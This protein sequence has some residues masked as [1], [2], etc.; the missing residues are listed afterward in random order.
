MS[1]TR[2]GFALVELLVATLVGAALTMLVGRLLLESAAVLRHRSERMGLEHSVRVSVGALRAMLEPLGVDSGSGADLAAG[3][4]STFVAR[5]VRGSG[6]LC[7]AALDRVLIR[8][9]PAWWRGLRIPVKNRDSLIVASV[10]GSERWI[11][12]PLTGNPAAGICPD[13]SAALVL[14]TAIAP[15]SLPS[16]GAGS[17]LQIIEPVE[18]R[19]Y[20]SSG[21]IWLGL[22]LAATGEAIQPLAGPFAATG[23]GLGY[24]DLQG[25]PALNGPLVAMVTMG[26]D[27]VTERAGGVGVVRLGQVQ[28]DSVR[29]AVSLRGRQ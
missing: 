24:Q 20:P 8:A 10:A 27:G 4:P 25:N 18:L 13:G 19:I 17:P 26:L 21:A 12:A 7:E 6:A 11:V 1:L 15:S 23:P 5:I 22:R 16:L 2:R 29:V 14:P 28:S 3:G 9:G